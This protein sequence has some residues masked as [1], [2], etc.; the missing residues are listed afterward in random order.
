[1][2]VKISSKDLY[3]RVGIVRPK[4]FGGT[5]SG[6]SA[7]DDDQSG[8]CHH[9]GI[10]SKPAAVTRQSASPPDRLRLIRIALPALRMFRLAGAARSCQLAGIPDRLPADLFD[11]AKQRR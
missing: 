8:F 10:P 2:E 5:D 6:R 11:N 4:R 1:M 7:P 3:R 9:C